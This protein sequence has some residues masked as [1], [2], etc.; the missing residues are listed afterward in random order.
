M[1]SFLVKGSKENA[2]AFSTIV[3]RCGLPRKIGEQRGQ[4]MSTRNQDRH[5]PSLLQ[6]REQHESKADAS[7]RSLASR[8]KSSKKDVPYLFIF[9]ALLFFLIVL[10]IAFE[11]FLIAL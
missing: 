6:Q 11:Y 7:S 9:F 3:G 8:Q 2:S 5:K 10:M 1:R 4:Q